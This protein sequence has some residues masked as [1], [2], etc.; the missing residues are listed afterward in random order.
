MNA[1]KKQRLEDAGFRVGTPADF[2]Q[3]S[4]ADCELIELR[5]LLDAAIRERKSIS[6]VSE[7]THQ[8]PEPAHGEPTFDALLH[9]YFSTGAS[10]RELIQ[11]MNAKLPVLS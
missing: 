9:D 1:A 2:L 8:S 10:L 3:L 11:V 4:T 7:A 6:N 5:L